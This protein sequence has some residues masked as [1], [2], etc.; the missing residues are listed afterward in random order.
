[1]LDQLMTSSAMDQEQEKKSSTSSVSPL[2]FSF[3][4]V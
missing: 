4:F 2:F 1:M 3:V